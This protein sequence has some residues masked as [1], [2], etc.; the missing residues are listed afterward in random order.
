[1]TAQNSGHLTVTVMSTE[2]VHRSAHY[3]N[4]GYQ[5]DA[6][7][8]DG[9]ETLDVTISTYLSSPGTMHKQL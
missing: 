3:T 5:Q 1:V 7:G 2:V 8:A 4:R 9:F 6:A